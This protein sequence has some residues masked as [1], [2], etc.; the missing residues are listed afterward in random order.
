MDHKASKQQTGTKDQRISELERELR[1]TEEERIVAIEQ[2]ETLRQMLAEIH[3]ELG[4]LLTSSEIGAMFLDPQMHIK[5]ATPGIQKHFNI[6]PDDIGRPISDLVSN[7]LYDTLEHDVKQVIATSVLKEIVIASKNERWFNMR[8]LPHSTAN[9]VING[10][11]ITMTDVTNLKKTEDQFRDFGDK[12]LT[13][14]EKSSIVVWNQD[15][16]LRYT[17]IHNPHSAFKPEEII[18]KKDENLLSSEDA[19]NLTII[20]HKVLDTGVGT[21]EKVR[22]TIKGK[23]YY[24]DLTVE[25]LL[26]SKSN[27]VGI[28]CASME[29]SKKAYEQEGTK[30]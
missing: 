7:L 26:D 13:A 5:S 10:V 21:R 1:K 8:I 20:K 27:I 12:L 14:I 9:G 19:D 15:M 28:S 23:P 17:W 2:S 29:I 24:Y 22:T 30:R 25:P 6:I 16:E 4:S 11:M 3:D 18:G